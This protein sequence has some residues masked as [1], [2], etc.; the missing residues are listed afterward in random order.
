[1]V[2]TGSSLLQVYKSTA[3]LSRRVV[4]EKLEGLSFR[5]YTFE[6]GGKNKTFDQ[7][8]DIPNS[9]VVTDDVEIGHKNKIPLWLFGM[10]Y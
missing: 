10:L 1:M 2:F 3:D 6:I 8:K 4:Y 9:F 5:E 7:I